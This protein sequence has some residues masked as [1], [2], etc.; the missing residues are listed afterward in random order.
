MENKLTCEKVIE[1]V[2]EHYKD[3]NYEILGVKKRKNYS[4]TFVKHDQMEEDLTGLYEGL[5]KILYT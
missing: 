3:T 2:K 5:A 1:I 4:I